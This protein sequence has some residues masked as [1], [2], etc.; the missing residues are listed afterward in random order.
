MEPSASPAG[1]VTCS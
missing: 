1:S